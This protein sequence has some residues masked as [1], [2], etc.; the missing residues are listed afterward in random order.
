MQLVTSVL[1]LVLRFVSVFTRCSYYWRHA[2]AGEYIG[3][4][5]IPSYYWHHICADDPR[6]PLGLIIVTL[7]HNNYNFPPFSQR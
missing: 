4:V 5:G 3:L 2:C 7:V 1:V 6:A